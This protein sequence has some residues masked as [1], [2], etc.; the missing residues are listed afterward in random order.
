MISSKNQLLAKWRQAACSWSGN[1]HVHAS[2][3]LGFS[4]NVT[5]H[6][7]INNHQQ[8]SAT[9]TKLAQQ[10]C[11]PFTTQCDILCRNGESTHTCGPAMADLKA[12]VLPVHCI[13][14]APEG[15]PD[16]GDLQGHM[17][18]ICPSGPAGGGCCGVLQLPSNIY[19]LQFEMQM[20]FST[21]LVE[22][23]N[24]QDS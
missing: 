11:S 18:S 6:N 14:A 20:E 5:K 9:S 17:H 22:H 8:I 4:V 21:E 23:F 1:L 15:P 12:A 19:Q 24:T 3:K 2:S 7:L 10:P 13:P 16:G